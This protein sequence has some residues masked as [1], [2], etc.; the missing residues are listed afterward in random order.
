MLALLA[1]SRDEGEARAIQ[2]ALSKEA[3]LLDGF[4]EVGS[5]NLMLSLQ[6]GGI[7]QK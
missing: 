1:T 6:C 5:L 3:G 4:I 2:S 7:P